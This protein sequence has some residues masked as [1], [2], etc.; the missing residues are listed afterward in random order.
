M[1]RE[2][3]VGFPIHILLKEPR[4]FKVVKFIFPGSNL[5]SLKKKKKKTLSF[6]CVHHPSSFGKKNFLLNIICCVQLLR[7]SKTMC[8]LVAY[9]TLEQFL[10]NIRI[11]LIVLFNLWFLSLQQLIL[12]LRE[13]KG[14]DFNKESDGRNVKK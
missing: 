13:R 1:L 3:A 9:N 4:I 11:T 12:R 2:S 8:F 7:L 10:P 14:K 6:K 5:N